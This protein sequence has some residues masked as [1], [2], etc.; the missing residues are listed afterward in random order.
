MSCAGPPDWIPQ[1]AESVIRGRPLAAGSVKVIT[2]DGSAQ[3]LAEWRAEYAHEAAAVAEGLCPAHRTGMHPVNMDGAAVAGHCSPCGK[4]WFY[5]AR[6][7][8]VGWT[9]DHDPR[10]GSWRPPS[11][12]ARGAPR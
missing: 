3:R 1:C 9:L 11:R 8:E 5:D 2:G 4:Y 10:D 7:E 6:N 12:P